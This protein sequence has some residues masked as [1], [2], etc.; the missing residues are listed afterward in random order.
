MK[1]KEES[2]KQLSGEAPK[3]TQEERDRKKLVGKAAK[4][5]KKKE[6]EKEHDKI[7]YRPHG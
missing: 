5:E 4:E 7:L 3:L 2:D 6:M 1:E